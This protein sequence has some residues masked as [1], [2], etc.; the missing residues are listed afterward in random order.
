MRYFLL[1]FANA[2]THGVV[3]C[4]ATKKRIVFSCNVA[5]FCNG[6]GRIDA[7]EKVVACAERCKRHILLKFRVIL[8]CHAN[9]G[10]R[11]VHA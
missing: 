5:G 7:I 10:E 1:K 4:G 11:F 8:L 9:G 6:Q 2:S 3:E